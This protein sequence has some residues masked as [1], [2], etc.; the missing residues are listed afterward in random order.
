MRLKS[1]IEVHGS[2]LV[3][4]ATFSPALHLDYETGYVLQ[5]HV[6]HLFVLVLVE[7]GPVLIDDPAVAVLKTLRRSAKI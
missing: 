5:S 4:K 7:E 2:V 1:L 3:D 6:Q